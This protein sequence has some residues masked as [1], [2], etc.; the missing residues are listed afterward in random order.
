M[1]AILVSPTDPKVIA[2][3]DII[4]GGILFNLIF[5]PSTITLVVIVL[6]SEVSSTYKYW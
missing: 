4:L 2:I 3:V 5:L 6:C 1:L